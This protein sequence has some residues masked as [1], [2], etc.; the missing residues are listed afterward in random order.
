MFTEGK[1]CGTERFFDTAFNGSQ[2]L[3][4]IQDLSNNDK[5][6]Y[7]P[8]DGGFSGKSPRFD[9]I[10][11][12]MKMTTKAQ[13]GSFVTLTF[14]K[15]GSALVSGDG[16]AKVIIT[17]NILDKDGNNMGDLHKTALEALRVWELLLRD[18]GL[19]V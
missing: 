16:T 15:Q 10:H 9:D 2:E 4:V 3:K 7:P 19:E 13:K 6:G 1:R 11:S 8:R 5:H 18:F 17:G 12:T 14:T